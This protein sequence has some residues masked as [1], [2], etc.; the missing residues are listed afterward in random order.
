MV[1]TPVPPYSGPCLSVPLDAVVR[2]PVI[3][4]GLDL[5]GTAELSC[6]TETMTDT[7]RSIR[8]RKV[9]LSSAEE[10]PPHSSLLI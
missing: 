8:A 10:P 3:R 5:D 6:R 9:R 2:P 1:P 7:R 4:P